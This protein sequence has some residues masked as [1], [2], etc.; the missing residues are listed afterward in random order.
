IFRDQPNAAVILGDVASVDVPGKRVI[1]VDGEV[2]YDYLVLATGATHSYFGHDDWRR[3][4]PGLKSLEDAMEIRRRVFSAFEIAERET[5]A[6]RR[7]AW[8]TFVVIGA[9]P[10]GV[11]LSGALAEVARSTLAHEFRH[12]DPR[13]ARIILVEGCPRVLSA[14]IEPLSASARRQL[15]A[16]GVEVRTGAHVTSIDVGG[17]SIGA[18]RIEARTVLWAAGVAAARVSASVGGWLDKAGR[19][20]AGPDLTTPGRDD[21]YVIGDLAHFEQD[22]ALVPGVAPAAMQQGSHAAANILRRI[23]GELPEPFRYTDK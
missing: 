2:P 5:V 21:V 8:M 4:A 14:F 7:S 16:L 20:L 13:R 17:V 11:E 10:T 22:G 9:G 1:L 18:E 15:E 6:A 19:V 3:L 12:I 23:R